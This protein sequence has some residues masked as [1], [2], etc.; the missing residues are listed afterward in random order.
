LLFSRRHG[1][2]GFVEWHAERHSLKKAFKIL[3]L[4]TPVDERRGVGAADDKIFCRCQRRHQGK[5]L[6]DHADAQRLRV[7]G[8]ANG[9]LAPVEQQLAAVGDVEAH[10]AFDESR[11]SRA[12]LAEQR[13]KRSGRN[14]D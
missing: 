8:I 6:I 14:L 11:F 12:V 9:H 2:D 1:R 5:M 13:V 10:D 3:S 4:F 7:L